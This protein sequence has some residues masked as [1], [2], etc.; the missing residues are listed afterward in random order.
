MKFVQKGSSAFVRFG[1]DEAR[2]HS[3]GETVCDEISGHQLH[4]F[5]IQRVLVQAL[6]QVSDGGV[7]ALEV[8][9]AGNEMPHGEFRPQ[10]CREVNDRT[11]SLWTLEQ[12]V[13]IIP[14]E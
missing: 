11:G 13:R 6:T 9:D 10:R 12:L 3:A 1:L 5:V 4:E 7:V 14:I 8:E 2:C